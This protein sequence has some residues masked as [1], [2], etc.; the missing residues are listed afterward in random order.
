LS[1]DGI[2]GGGGTGSGFGFGFTGGFGGDATTA[3]E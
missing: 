3:K 1:F 2:T